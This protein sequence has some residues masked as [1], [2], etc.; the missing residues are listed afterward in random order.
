MANL[1]EE[2]FIRHTHADSATKLPTAAAGVSSDIFRALGRF[3]LLLHLY[4]HICLDA[5]VN[6]TSMQ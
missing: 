2:D 4:H 6:K 5:C 1:N 3:F